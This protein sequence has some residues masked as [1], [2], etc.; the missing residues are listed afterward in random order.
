MTL[1][2]DRA[3]AGDVRLGAVG[4]AAPAQLGY[5]AQLVLVARRHADAERPAG[6]GPG[7][8][9]RAGGLPGRRR[10]AAERGPPV[11]GEPLGAE[12]HGQVRLGPVAREL[13]PGAELG[14]VA[15]VRLRPGGAELV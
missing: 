3:G 7:V 12:A 14:G 6:L 1:A 5:S 11:G 8:L 2:G 13:S 9:G 4:L 15:D 10:G